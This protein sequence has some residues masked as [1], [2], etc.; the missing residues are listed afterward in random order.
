VLEST[1]LHR[2]DAIFGRLERVD[3][4]ELVGIPPGSY[5]VNKLLIGDVHNITSRDGF[6]YGLG[7]YVGLY[8]FPKAL[9]PFYGSNPTTFGVFLRVRP[10]KM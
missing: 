6:D 7:A 9:D 2:N 3:K 1:L 8:K 10:S 5:T 4:D